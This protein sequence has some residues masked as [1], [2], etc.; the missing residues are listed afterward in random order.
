MRVCLSF[1]LF[2]SK[3]KR[4]DLFSNSETTE[5]EQEWIFCFV[6]AL[7]DH[8]GPDV[9]ICVKYHFNPGFGQNRL[10]PNYVKFMFLLACLRIA[11][12]GFAYALLL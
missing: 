6:F 3:L 1:C 11:Q 4:F 9:A 2:C 12:S 7:N 8:S 5:I 10:Q